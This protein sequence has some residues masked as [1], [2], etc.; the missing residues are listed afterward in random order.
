MACGWHPLISCIFQRFSAPESK[1]VILGEMRVG[2]CT[3]RVFNKETGIAAYQDVLKTEVTEGKVNFVMNEA[4]SG[5]EFRF[6]YTYT[7]AVISASIN[8]TIHSTNT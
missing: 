7:Q 3:F 8:C 4:D 2:A 5:R 6:I 1:Y